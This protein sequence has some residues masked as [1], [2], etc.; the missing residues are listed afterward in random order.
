MIWLEGK[1]FLTIVDTIRVLLSNYFL[2]KIYLIN[3]NEF[4]I[5]FYCNLNLKF[6][7]ISYGFVIINWDWPIITPCGQKGG[8]EHGLGIKAESCNVK[9]DSSRNFGVFLKE[10]Q[11]NDSALTMLQLGFI[12]LILHSLLF[13]FLFSN[14]RGD[15]RANSSP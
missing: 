12:W 15:T 8:N 14:I 7:I 9:Q 2:I 11:T 3:I 1:Y 10:R 4:I 5:R 6:S 13:H